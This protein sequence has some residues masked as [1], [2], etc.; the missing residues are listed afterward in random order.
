[1]QKG[2]RCGPTYA[3]NVKAL[4]DQERAIAEQ[5]ERAYEHLVGRWRPK[6]GES[7]TG[8]AAAAGSS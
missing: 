5:A 3:Y 4:R 6:P 8:A 7:G 2:N 1:M